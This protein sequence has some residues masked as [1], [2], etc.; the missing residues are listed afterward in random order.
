VYFGS[1]GLGLFEK[2]L[3]RSSGPQYLGDLLPG[4][5]TGGKDGEGSGVFSPKSDV[6]EKRSAEETVHT[7]TNRRM[8]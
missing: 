6:V 2:K 5:R 3:A 1:C 7:S 4:C 8:P